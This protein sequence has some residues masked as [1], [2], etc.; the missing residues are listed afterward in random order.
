MPGQL[1]PTAPCNPAGGF[2]RRTMPLIITDQSPIGTVAIA[3]SEDPDRTIALIIGPG[4]LKSITANAELICH[5]FNAH[6]D[7]VKSRD[8]LLAACQYALDTLED[9]C[10]Y[11]RNIQTRLKAAIAIAGAEEPTP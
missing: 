6:E 4:T 10:T 11:E 9:S 7:L 5:H 2:E 3:H 1:T 8:E